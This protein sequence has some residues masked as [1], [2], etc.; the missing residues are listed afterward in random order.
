MGRLEVGSDDIAR[1]S[2]ERIFIAINGASEGGCNNPQRQGVFAALLDGHRANN[3]FGGIPTTA[4]DYS[5]VCDANLYEWNEDGI[6]NGY[7]GLLPEEVRILK[8]GRDAYINRP[9][10]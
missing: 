9:N 5:P 4:T 7:R 3:V 2:V 6:E 8:L 1:S 10:A